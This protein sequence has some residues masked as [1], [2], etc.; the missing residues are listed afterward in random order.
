MNAKSKKTVKITLVKSL[1]GTKQS[2]RATV[3]GLGLKRINSTAELEDT[4]AIRG[5]IQ[6]V[7][8]LV[9]CE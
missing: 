1:I 7:N 6:K 4:P 8:Y 5:M 9:K 2:H 3:K